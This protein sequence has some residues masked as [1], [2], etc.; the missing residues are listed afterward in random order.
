MYDIDIFY[1]YIINILMMYFIRMFTI[2]KNVTEFFEIFE[3]NWIYYTN[4]FDF[5]RTDIYTYN[6]YYISSLKAYFS[7]IEQVQ[8][9]KN[10]FAITTTLTCFSLLG[11]LYLL[12]RTLIRWERIQNT[13]RAVFRK[14]LVK[15]RCD[16]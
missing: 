16:L 13:L 12:G 8:R 14:N 3:T 1:K 11:M 6:S 9:L 15:V 4:H 2:I 7:I 10:W 5:F